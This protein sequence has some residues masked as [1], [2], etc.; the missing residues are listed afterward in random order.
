MQTEQHRHAYQGDCGAR[1]RGPEMFY[2]YCHDTGRMR[3]MDYTD[4]L[5]SMQASYSNLYGR[6]ADAMQPIIDFVTSM[7]GGSAAQTKRH[8]HHDEQ[9]CSCNCCIRCADLVEYA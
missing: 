8:Q 5:N 7:F 1:S 2:G 4:Y 3:M 9:D 6:S